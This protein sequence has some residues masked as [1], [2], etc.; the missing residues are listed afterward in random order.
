[1]LIRETAAAGMSRTQLSVLTTLR[2]GGA[3][4]ITELA[5]AER[6]AQPSMT[7]LVSRLERQGWAKRRP[8]PV[9]GRAVVVEI[10][11]A[12]V[13]E[14]DRMTA[15]RADLLARR[16]EELTPKE[17]A[18]LAAALPALDRIID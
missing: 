5:E 2:D 11:P 1:M 18:A 8:D 9:D 6:V 13:A 7:V 10:T 17:Q 16:L 4:R 12:G 15:A 14:L 3:A